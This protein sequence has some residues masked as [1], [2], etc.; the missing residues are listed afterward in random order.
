VPCQRQNALANSD[1]PKD[2]AAFADSGGE[3][4]VYGVEEEQRKATGRIDVGDLSE[5]YERTY[6]R[7]AR[8]LLR[9]AAQTCQRR[10]PLGQDVT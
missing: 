10:Q 9:C 1:V 8:A 2:I 4:L 3:V 6:R 7:V 5:G